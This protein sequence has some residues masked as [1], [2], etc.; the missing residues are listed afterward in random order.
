MMGRIA[1]FART[2][3][4]NGFRGCTGVAKAGEE[5]GIG[6]YGPAAGF[7]GAKKPAAGCGCGR[8]VLSSAF[9]WPDF[10]RFGRGLWTIMLTLICVL[11]RDFN[12]TRDRYN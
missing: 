12:K 10:D 2:G 7:L 6:L 8:G 5:E 9:I 1:A 11:Q 3:G 4:W